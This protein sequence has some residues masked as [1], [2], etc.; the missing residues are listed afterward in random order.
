ML[1]H[2][3]DPFRLNNIQHIRYSSI[4]AQEL[5]L[6]GLNLYVNYLHNQHL[7]IISLTLGS[8]AR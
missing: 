8:E 2:A 5:A 4:V 6:V 3:G 1:C 7:Y